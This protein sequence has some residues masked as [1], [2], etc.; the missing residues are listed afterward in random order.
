LCDK[1]SPEKWRALLKSL[2][3]SSTGVLSK[4]CFAELFYDEVIQML[5]I[6]NCGRNLYPVELCDKMHCGT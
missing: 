3:S 4:H 6:I 2:V 1:G 5:Y